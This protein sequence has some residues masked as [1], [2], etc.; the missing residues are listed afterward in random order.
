M[1]A[2]KLQ[3]SDCEEGQDLLKK[4]LTLTQESSQ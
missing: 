4:R 1:L 2:K 3:L